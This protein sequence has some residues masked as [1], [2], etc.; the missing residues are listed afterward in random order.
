MGDQKNLQIQWTLT[1]PNSLGPE[2]I[3]ISER[4]GFV[5]AMNIIIYNYVVM[6]IIKFSCALFRVMAVL[7][8]F[9]L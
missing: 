7:G 5:K 6:N 9:F 4:F 1:N 3:Q 8:A 2:A